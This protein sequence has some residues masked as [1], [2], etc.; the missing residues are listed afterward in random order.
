[1][2]VSALRSNRYLALFTFIIVVVSLSIGA[3]VSNAEVRLVYPLSNSPASIKGFDRLPYSGMKVGKNSI[4]VSGP[5]GSLA[6]L[7]DDTPL[8]MNKNWRVDITFK[9][10]RSP[11][12]CLQF[13]LMSIPIDGKFL[14]SKPS[15]RYFKLYGAMINIY[16]DGK[17][18]AS[19]FHPVKEIQAKV[20][21]PDTFRIEPERTYTIRLQNDAKRDRITV[22]LIRRNKRISEFSFDCQYWSKPNFAHIPRID[23][24]LYFINAGTIWPENPKAIP[25]WTVINVSVKREK[26]TKQKTIPYKIIP[27]PLSVYTEKDNT[28]FRFTNTINVIFPAGKKPQFR[29]AENILQKALS[30]LNCSFSDKGRKIYVGLCQAESSIGKLCA[31]L[32]LKPPAG[33]EGYLIKVTPKAI[34]LIGNSPRAVLYAIETFRQ[35]VRQIQS[36]KEIVCCEIRD[37]PAN[38]LRGLYLDFGAY[39]SPIIPSISNRKLIARWD[40]VRKILDKMSASKLNTLYFSNDSYFVNSDIPE[41]MNNIRKLVAMC[42]ERQIEF[43]PE[44][45]GLGHASAYTRRYPHYTEGMWYKNEKVTLHGTKPSELKHR[46]VLL[47]KK[48]KIIVKSTSGKIYEVNRDYR[49]IPGLTAAPFKNDNAPYKIARIPTGRI[50]NGQTVFVSYNA[51]PHQRHDYSYCPMEIEHLEKIER[52]I[53]HRFMREFKPRYISLG[54]DEVRCIC[55]DSRCIESGKTPSELFADDVLRVARYAREI[56]PQVEVIIFD[57]MLLGALSHPKR[58]THDA[59]LLLPKWITLLVWFYEDNEDQLIRASINYYTSRGF[60]VIAG[61]HRAHPINMELWSKWVPPLNANGLIKCPG[62][63]FLGWREQFDWNKMAA[64]AWGNYN[65]ANNRRK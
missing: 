58:P 57:D 53:V 36:A 56:D 32:N 26:V 13:A 50:K 9:M 6:A 52:P 51:V 18:I 60:R 10:G 46:N 31:K 40:D 54:R 24:A 1:M 17:V 2:T 12:A 42:K 28:T 8:N 62:Y 55:R 3:S 4:T 16:N 14:E 59:I 11:N 19:K 48:S 41:N 27:K 43:L 30:N 45:Q 34:Y 7:S 38:T 21:I 29:Y 47:T 65:R 20:E 44:F 22:S 37:L 49:I 5:A 39:V 23:P 15:K 63:I 64:T 33:E 25:D 61:P 35:I